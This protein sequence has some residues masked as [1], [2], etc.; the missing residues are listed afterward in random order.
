MY[1]LISIPAIKCNSNFP[2]VEKKGTVKGNE[3]SLVTSVTCYV[4]LYLEYSV[5]SYKQ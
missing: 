2:H 4:Q 5:F 1:L 3:T